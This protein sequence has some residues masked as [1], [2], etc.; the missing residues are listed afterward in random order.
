MADLVKSG[1]KK[2]AITPPSHTVLTPSDA[3]DTR[4]SD[5]NP[6]AQCQRGG[7][8]SMHADML[9]ELGAP[10]DLAKHLLTKSG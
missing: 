4:V 1:S 7:C 2:F 9:H 6:K 5:T 10:A 8:F 3:R